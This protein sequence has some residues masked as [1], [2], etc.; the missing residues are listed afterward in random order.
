MPSVSEKQ[1]NFMAMSRSKKGREALKHS[2]KDPAP[3]TVAKDYTMADK[4]KHFK[5]GKA[6]KKA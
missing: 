4:G 3:V 1:H 2:G 6:E 5:M